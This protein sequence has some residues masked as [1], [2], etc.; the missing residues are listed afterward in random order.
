MEALRHLLN[1][2]FAAILLNVKMPDMDG[3]QTAELI[4]S[5]RR[6]RHPISVDREYP[7]EKVL[8][9]NGFGSP[10]YSR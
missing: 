4:R 10:G 9:A 2:D 6:S 8:G 1:D 5:R 3:F 7:G